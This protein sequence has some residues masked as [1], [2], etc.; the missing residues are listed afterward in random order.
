V[1]GERTTKTVFRMLMAWNDEKEERWLS[2]Q[3]RSGWHLKEV[4][5]FGYTLERAAPAEVA[6]RLDFHRGPREDRQ[7]YLTLFRDAGW[8]ALGSRGHWYYFRRA[9]VDGKVPEIYTDPESRIAKYRQVM[10]LMGVMLVVLGVVI[11]PKA[12]FQTVQEPGRL[13]DRVYSYAFFV[14]LAAMGFL[15]YGIVR[16]SLVIGRLKKLRAGKA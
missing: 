7:E 10:A 3:A 16:L 13:V 14:K 5:G 1:S 15:L 9:V 11:A 8:E 12:P 4:R 2:E 6:Y